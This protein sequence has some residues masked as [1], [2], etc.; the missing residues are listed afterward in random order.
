MLEEGDQASTKQKVASF[1]PGRNR[2]RHSSFDVCAFGG[3]LFVLDDA[4][5]V[6]QRYQVTPVLG[7]NDVYG[8]HAGE[9]NLFHAGQQA[10][11]SLAGEG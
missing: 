2:G 10:I 3:V 9:E 7:N 6:H 8:D 5:L 4:L 11:Q 1:K